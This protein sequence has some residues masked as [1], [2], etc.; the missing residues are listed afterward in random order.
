MVC[1][2]IGVSRALQNLTGVSAASRRTP[3]TILSAF[4]SGLPDPTRGKEIEDAMI[5]LR[6]K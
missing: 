4:S 6:Q 2:R 1:F 5:L 3:G